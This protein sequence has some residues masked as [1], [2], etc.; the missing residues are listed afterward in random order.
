MVVFFNQQIILKSVNFG[1]EG[2]Y[3]SSMA[4]IGRNIFDHIEDHHIDQTKVINNHK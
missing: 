1:T 3:I 4:L 2:Q